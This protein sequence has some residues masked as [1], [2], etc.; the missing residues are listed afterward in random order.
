MKILHIITG[1]ENG[2]AEAVLYRLCTY[3]TGNEHIVVS[4]TG[5]GKYGQLLVQAKI[6]VH[7]L[8][9]EFKFL[10]INKFIYLIEL[11]KQ[12]NP[13]VVQTWLYHADFLGGL[14]ARLAG[15]QSVY[16]G[17][18]NSTLSREKTPLMTRLIV[19]A[20]ALL[21]YFIPKKIIVCGKVPLRHHEKIGYDKSKMCVIYNGYDTN[22]FK[23]NPFLKR[24]IDGVAYNVPLLGMIARYAPQKDHENLFN[25][26]KILKSSGFLFKCILIGAGLNSRNQEL[27]YKINRYDLSDIIILLGERS[28]LPTIIPA[29]DIHILS[30]AYGEAFPNVICEAMAC[31]VPCVATDIGDCSEIIGNRGWVVP[32]SDPQKLASTIMKAFQ[33]KQQLSENQIRERIVLNYGIQRMIS[34]YNEKWNES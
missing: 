21:S 2:G 33:T 8:R 30:S 20:L 10:A 24:K 1:L 15:V 12:N 13:D 25:S 11:I 32:P 26:L 19:K 6:P 7:A 22:V 5:L 27:L 17:V 18:H 9:F 14:A 4:L 16:W 3:D 23:P 34:S 29:L 28:D 31:G